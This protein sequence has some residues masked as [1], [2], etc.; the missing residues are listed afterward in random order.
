MSVIHKEDMGNVAKERKRLKRTDIIEIRRLHKEGRKI[1][2]LA[3]KY[4]KHHQ[5]I[6]NIIHFRSHKEVADTGASYE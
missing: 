6:S 5:T 2:S 1:K 4:K 3:E